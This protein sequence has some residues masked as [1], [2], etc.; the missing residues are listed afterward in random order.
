MP[1]PDLAI[2][3]AKRRRAY[4]QTFG[5]RDVA[6]AVMEVKM[7]ETSIVLFLPSHESAKRPH[8]ADPTP[9]FTHLVSVSVYY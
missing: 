1:I 8:T 4:T 2:P 9:K 3:I 7:Q 6:K 5:E